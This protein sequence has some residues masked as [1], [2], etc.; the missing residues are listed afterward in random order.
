[1]N[2]PGFQTVT[3][4]LGGMDTRLRPEQ[5]TASLIENMRYCP[6]DGTWATM[7]GTVSVGS[8]STTGV[9]LKWFNPRPNQKFLVVERRASAD[10]NTL[11]WLRVQNGSLVQIA[12]RRRV[13]NDDGGAEVFTE[14]GRWLYFTS[15]WNAPL[16]WDG[17]DTMPVGFDR[18]PPPLEAYGPDQGVTIFDRMSGRYETLG[19]DD[20]NR[21][22]WNTLVQ[23]G[24][25]ERRADST[26]P[27]APFRYGYGYT[28]VNDLGQESPMSPLA[29]ASGESSA[30]TGR[31]MIRLRFPALPRNVRGIRLWRTINVAGTQ[32]NTG[33]PMYLHST[34]PVAHGFD[35]VDHRPDLELTEEWDPD[36][37]GTV[38]AGARAMV[39]WQGSLWLAGM[40]DDPNGLRY[41]A[42]QYPEQFPTVNR[43]TVGGYH[44]GRVLALVPVPRGLVVLKSSGTYIVKGS[45]IEGYRVEVVDETV[46]L[47]ARRAVTYVP[48]QGLV[49]LHSSGPK[50]MVGTLSDDEPT[51]VKDAA[52][53]MTDYWRRMVRGTRIEA[54]VCVYDPT[55]QEVWFHVP[56]QGDNRPSLGLVLHTATGAWSTRTGWD[57][58]GFDVFR[59][60]LY[61]CGWNS[62]SVYRFTPGSRTPNLSAGSTITSNYA[63]SP[64][65]L[66]QPTSVDRVTVFGRALGSANTFSLDTRMDRAATW[67]SQT[68]TAA[69]GMVTLMRD[70]PEWGTALWSAS[71]TWDDEHPTLTPVSLRTRTGRL[72]ELRIRSSTR[73]V[74]AD[75]TLSAQPGAAGPPPLERP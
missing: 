41:S 10:T 67:T 49:W 31:R 5:G 19:T 75:L 3:L 18:A 29:W 11:S 32:T 34:F 39:F 66:E 16:R 59:G 45:P 21:V 54:A 25:G 69:R 70:A 9:G 23:R 63:T 15:A 7:E 17:T 62:A 26:D 64:L 44:T 42:P 8:L 56:H 37:V 51:R 71:G 57:I 72:V 27:E 35:F 52:P 68:E 73:L 48:D 47:A 40:V 6:G 20:D 46:G 14:L 60:A 4:P 58:A 38:P 30:S 12:N 55:H 65:V 13:E 1:M 43:L 24:V 36:S 28:A 74:V 50:V 53:G 2:A 61:A 33:L 22:E